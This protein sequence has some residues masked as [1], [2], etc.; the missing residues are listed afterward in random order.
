M[1]DPSIYQRAYSAQNVKTIKK[2]FLISIIFWFIFDAMTIS[3]GLYASAIITS[4]IYDNTSSPY[5]QLANI[6]LPN[7]Y[8][9]TIFL[10][11]LLAIV[12][13]TID[14]T[15]FISSL[16][17]NNFIKRIFKQKIKQ[18]INWGLIIT[19][20]LSIIL[21]YYFN[22][23]IGYW[24]IFGSIAS[25]TLLI[26]FI[27][28]LYLEIY[29][30]KRP[31]LSLLIPFITTIYFIINQIINYNSI[32]PIFPGMLSSIFINTINVSKIKKL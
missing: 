1:I 15:T 19:S 4:D 2:G 31:G 28:T 21:C 11:S 26:P 14:S 30:L 29:T 7:Y 24:Y 13:S 12:M 5:L 16:T 23:A 27:I 8:L 32:Y 25:F 3:T 22:E 6:I 17:F 9:N 20:I 10:I 18:N